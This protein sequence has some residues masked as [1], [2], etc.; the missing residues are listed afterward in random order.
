MKLKRIRIR[1]NE[2]GADTFSL[3]GKPAIQITHICLSEEQPDIIE[4]MLADKEKKQIVSPLLIP[5]K[6]IYRSAESLNDDE[7]ALIYWSAATIKREQ[8]NIMKSYVNQPI[9]LDH[10]SETEDAYILECWIKEDDK[11][12]K[13]DQ[14]Y[15][16]AGVIPVGTLLFKL[17]ITSDSLW[18]DIK[19]GKYNGLSVEGKYSFDEIEAEEEIYADDLE[20]LVDII[21][22]TIA[23]IKNIS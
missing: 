1:K 13:R 8:Q 4:I 23:Q 3:V 2:E 6:K 15:Y 7:D 5:D 20:A 16:D 17:Q 10:A 18:D 11:L 19:S 9:K 12:D 21:T 14:L 22:E